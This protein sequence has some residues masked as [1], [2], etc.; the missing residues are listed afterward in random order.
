MR[1][2]CFY[3]LNMR[4]YGVTLLLWC[5][6]PVTCPSFSLSVLRTLQPLTVLVPSQQNP[7]LPLYSYQLALR[8]CLSIPWRTLSLYLIQPRNPVGHSFFLACVVVHHRCTCHL[9]FLTSEVSVS[10]QALAHRGHSSR[11][12]SESGP[13]VLISLLIALCTTYLLY[14]TSLPDQSVSCTQLFPLTYRTACF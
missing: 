9:L 11:G 8:L 12:A 4:Q 1:R 6:Q 2:R 3:S 5:L 10:P 14:L 7:P 13:C